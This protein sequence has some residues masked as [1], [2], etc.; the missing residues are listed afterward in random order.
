MRL[1]AKA[2]SIAVYE[3]L[4]TAVDHGAPRALSASVPLSI[5]VVSA[6]DDD[7]DDSILSAAASGAALSIV[8]LTESARP[9]VNENTLVGVVVARVT[10]GEGAIRGTSS[11]ASGAK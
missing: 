3:L 1:A 4:V 5:V 7:A 2:P 9:L 6:D 8:W 10:V 11:S